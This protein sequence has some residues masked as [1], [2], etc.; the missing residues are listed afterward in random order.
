MSGLVLGAVGIEIEQVEHLHLGSFQL[1]SSGQNPKHRSFPRICTRTNLGQALPRDPARFLQL[2]GREAVLVHPLLQAGAFRSPQRDARPSIGLRHADSSPTDR[3][4]I[5]ATIRAARIARGH[6]QQSLAKAAKVSR[7]NLA[8]LEQGGNVSIRYLLKIARVL[9]LTDIPLGGTV[10]LTSGREDGLN[11]FGLLQSFD[12]IAAVVD[13]LRGAVVNAVLPPSEHADL[14]DSAVLKELA[15][16]HADKPSGVGRPAK[17]VADLP[18]DEPSSA[19]SR[20][21]V[22][23]EPRPPRSRTK[24][25]PVRELPR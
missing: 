25:R 17:V 24:K 15:A 9:E 1:P 3:S 21:V 4:M 10:Q 5:G 2:H 16:K 13:H 12:V 19:S 22:G 7:G 11:V 14:K 6:T 23:K 20:F 18:E 8:L